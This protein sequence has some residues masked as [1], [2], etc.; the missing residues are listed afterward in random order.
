[1][2]ICH[3][4]GN[5]YF[6]EME[7]KRLV[8]HASLVTNHQLS[9]HLYNCNAPVSIYPCNSKGYEAKNA[10]ITIIIQSNLVTEVRV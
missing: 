9:T 10:Y 7:F 6:Q 8:F 5:S 4:S 1:M 3:T 2:Y